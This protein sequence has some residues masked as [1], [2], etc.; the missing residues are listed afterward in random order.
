MKKFCRQIVLLICGVLY[1]WA[2]QPSDQYIPVELKAPTFG[3]IEINITIIDTSVYVPSIEVLTF[4]GIKAEYDSL[5]QIISGI[6]KSSDN[7]Y[8]I[9]LISNLAKIKNKKSIELAPED[10]LF[11]DNVLFLRLTTINKIFE[12][13]LIYYPRKLQILVKN[14]LDIPAVIVARRLKSLQQRIRPM[15]F[16]EPEVVLGREIKFINGGRLDWSSS[17]RFINNPA[18]SS[19]LK[20]IDS[21]DNLYFGI[22]SLGGDLTGHLFSVIQPKQTKNTFRWKMRYPVFD[23][24]YLRQIT[25]GDIYN[26]GVI[27]Q[28]MSGIEFTNRPAAARRLFTREVFH[29]TVE[30]NMNVST[31]GG[32]GEMNLFKADDQ[33]LYQ[34]DAPVL[35]GN[36]LLEVRAF[37]NWGQERLLRYRLVVPR[38]L[39]PPGEAEYSIA[40][41]TIKGN[42]R[43]KTFTSTLNWGISSNLSVGTKIAYYDFK[44]PTK[45][46]GGISGTSR[47]TGNLIFDAL[48][49][50]KGI[51]QANLN[52]EFPS[53]ARFTVSNTYYGTRSA[54]DLSGMRN[55]LSASASIP[56]FKGLNSYVINLFGTRTEYTD[57][58][59]DQVQVSFSTV[60]KKVSPTIST[61]WLSQQQFNGNRITI[62]QESNAGLSTTLPAGLN[63]RGDLR[64]DHLQHRIVSINVV[65]VK[66]FSNNFLLSASYLR[67]F[68]PSYYSIGFRLSYYFPFVRAQVGAATSGRDRYEYSLTGSGAVDFDLVHP[69]VKF[70]DVHGSIIDSRGF[71]IRPFLD[72]NANGIFDKDESPLDGGRV[73]YQNVTFENQFSSMPIN[74]INR[75]GFYSYEKYNFYLD[76][77]SLENPLW[78]PEFGGIQVMSEPNYLRRIDIP[79]VTGGIVRGTV[80]VSTKAT[81][82]AEGIK[83]TL[84]VVSQNTDENK[85][86]GFISKFKKTVSTFSTGEFEFIGVPPGRYILELDAE[87]LSNLRYRC[88]PLKRDINISIKEDGDLLNDQNFTLTISQ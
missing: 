19:Q 86:N 79:V 17:T 9:D 1:S 82:P 20:F 88:M 12:L 57:Y 48:V 10:Y 31:S 84:Y 75:R 54:F 74:K 76:P 29:G 40:T 63:L 45:F 87:Q 77:Q 13:E 80:M 66:Y 61:R 28:E 62:A 55:E 53:T 14:V 47:L 60:L 52:W 50:P 37:D 22:K 85:V 4:L 11:K 16:T 43:I 38:S 56:F 36:G 39:I 24:P 30:P 81:I 44:Y 8:S 26:I 58:R 64:Y 71:F 73:Y 65:G 49:I 21:R 41:G 67:A 2:Q 15:R 83:V 5:N 72:Q 59:N 78:V 68:R 46:Y 23:T 6:F 27:S 42:K 70:S 69:S 3:S 32:I 51:A 25:F 7:A 35:Y 34:F 33:G 18:S